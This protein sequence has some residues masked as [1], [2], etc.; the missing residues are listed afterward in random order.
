MWASL[1]RA[2]GGGINQ[3]A[4]GEPSPPS[5]SGGVTLRQAGELASGMR[6]S[7]VNLAIQR[8]CEQDHAARLHKELSEV[9]QEW[10]VQ[11]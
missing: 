6:V 8:F 2:I 1:L 9:L 3:L 4:N 5:P 7:A 10:R 11:D